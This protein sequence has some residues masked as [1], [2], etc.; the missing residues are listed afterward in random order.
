[1]SNLPALIEKVKGL[2]PREI[3]V[4]H[5]M[6]GRR[7]LRHQ[8]GCSYC[9]SNRPTIAALQARVGDEG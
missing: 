4:F 6:C 2:R 1:M 8:C 3:A 5:N 7:T 9:V